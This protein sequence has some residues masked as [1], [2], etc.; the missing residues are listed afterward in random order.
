MSQALDSPGVIYI[1]TYMRLLHILAPSYISRQGRRLNVCQNLEI[2][3]L[4][5]CFEISRI[6]LCYKFSL[7]FFFIHLLFKLRHIFPHE[8]ENI[9]LVHFLCHDVS[10]LFLHINRQLS[11][12]RYHGR[13]ERQSSL[14]PCTNH[15]TFHLIIMEIRYYAF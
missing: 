11:Y 6:D 3:T 4:L 14:N 9:D 8:K 1:I 2:I 10:I 5:P 13:M 12:P 7:S 15:Y